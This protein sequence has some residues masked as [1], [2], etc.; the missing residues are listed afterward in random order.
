MGHVLALGEVGQE[1]ALLDAV[2]QTGTAVGCAVERSGQVQEPVR[3][4]GAAAD[5]LLEVED[6]A[7]AGRDLADPGV[8]G[9]PGLAPA[10][11]LLAEVGR[12][13][14]AVTG[15]SR[16]GGVGVQ[17]EGAPHD[18]H[19]E[20][21]QGDRRLQATLADV[22]PGAHDVRPDLDGQRGG[23]RGRRAHVLLQRDP[24][25]GCSGSEPGDR[26]DVLVELR[27]L[28]GRHRGAGAP[29]RV[30]V[31]LG[32]RSARFARSTDVTGADLPVADDVLERAL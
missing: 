4:G 8:H 3:V 12:D 25:P 22:A 19:V 14:T 15:L 28:L 31:V 30:E 7:V 9:Q 27:G 21:G 1:Q 13:I 6:Q 29:D 32:R 18:A 16:A 20:A 26:G 2:L 17:L 23:G 5:R 24:A 10:A 11:V